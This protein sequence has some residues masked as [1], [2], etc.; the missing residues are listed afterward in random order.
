MRRDRGFV[1]AASFVLLSIGSAVYLTVVTVNYLNYYPALGQVYVRT[2]SVFIVPG[3]NNSMI[4]SGVSVVNP[5]DYVGF[6]LGEAIVTLSFH[7]SDTNATLFGG[8]HL[9]QSETVGVELAPHSTVSR[10]L[11]FQ[12]NAE[13]ANSF[14]S[15]VK[16]YAGRIVATV[17]LTVQVITFL[18]TVTGRDYYMVTQDLPLSSS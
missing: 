6:R 11:I 9:V 5:T 10:N 7:V 14:S 8:V 3:S 18:N 1:I 13:D 12:L 17:V 15:F 4:S 2:D 16:T